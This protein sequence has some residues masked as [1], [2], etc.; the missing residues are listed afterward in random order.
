V[1]ETIQSLKPDVIVNCAGFVDVERA[2]SERETAWRINTSAVEYL[3]DAA[4]KT[5]ARI[6]HI[7]SDYI[8]D[9]VRSPYNETAAPNPLN[10]YGRTKLAS[11]NALRSSGIHHCILRLTMLYGTDPIKKKNIIELL[12]LTVKQAKQFTAYTDV[13]TAPTYITDAAFAVVRLTEK[14]KHGIY[15][16]C[17]PE[18][19]S[20][21][22]FARRIARAFNLDE[23]FLVGIS[24]AELEAGGGRAIR[25]KHTS[26]ITLKIQTELS[27]RP[28]TIDEGIQIVSRERKESNETG[29]SFIYT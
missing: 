27:L 22:D 5:D 11:E 1:R 29:R 3:I 18:Q 17:G 21:Y 19:V 6:V 12:P 16:L 4:R 20:R 23:S 2:E 24:A 14:Y 10:Y 26:F 25:P 13:I 8:F 28:T 9:G 7:S 15:H